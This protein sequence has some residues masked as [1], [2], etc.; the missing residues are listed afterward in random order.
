MF[1]SL[2]SQRGIWLLSVLCLL[3]LGFVSCATEKVEI[4]RQQLVDA[5]AV[6]SSAA[7][8]RSFSYDFSE[9]FV[10]SLS[11]ILVSEI[12]DKTFFIAAIMAMRNS[13][14]SVFAGAMGA[15]FL[16]TVL[17]TAVGYAAT[18]ISRVYTF[19]AS[20][21]MFV[22]F[23]VKML[24]EGYEMSPTHGQEEMEEVNNE[25]SKK[26]DS[27]PDVSLEGGGTA[28]PGGSASHP[29]SAVHTQPRVL[30]AKVHAVLSDILS[31][32]FLQVFTLT[33]VAEWG[34]RSQ[35]STIV[36]GAQK[37][38]YAVAL[39]GV[40][41]HAVCT[42]GAV[43]GGRLLAQQI[44]VRT[45]TLLGGVTFLFFAALSLAHGP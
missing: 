14:V 15:L 35:I 43:L 27:E 31:P 11:V 19:Y 26:I 13:R 17:S 21:V 20:V 8:S 2:F 33:F 18:V 24:K 6:P 12:G 22:V 45:V 32:V 39:G 29:S 9:A 1:S 37:N 42:G 5:P 28:T 16:M 36:L 38:P 4:D 7:Q 25:L 34:D 3:R 23:G 41:G 40:L 30:R 44:S 10:A